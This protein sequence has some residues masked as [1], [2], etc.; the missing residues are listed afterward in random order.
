MLSTYGAVGGIVGD[1][2]PLSVN[3]EE[4]IV[5]IISHFSHRRNHSV[6]ETEV[7]SLIRYSAKT[8]ESLLIEVIRCC[9]NS[10]KI[11]GSLHGLYCNKN[12]CKRNSPGSL[13]VSRCGISFANS[14]FI[15]FEI[16]ML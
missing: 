5:V 15:S 14:L 8:I 10:D 9:N 1:Q 4:K 7:Y 16:K 6:D 11:I 13:Y 3:S 2:I 12:N